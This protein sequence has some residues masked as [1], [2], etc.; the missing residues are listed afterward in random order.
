MCRWLW[1]HIRWDKA[2]KKENSK[3]TTPTTSSHIA[4]E[5]A[6]PVLD[7]AVAEDADDS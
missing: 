4:E 1:R 2:E 7:C 5:T 3:E 6:T